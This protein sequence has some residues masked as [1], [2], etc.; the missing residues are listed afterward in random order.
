MRE[1][2]Q[3]TFLDVV[4]LVD[5]N[6]LTLRPSWHYAKSMEQEDKFPPEVWITLA[7]AHYLKKKKN[8]GRGNCKM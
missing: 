6:A 5:G 8:D 7:E 3:L 1:E 2:L 4:F